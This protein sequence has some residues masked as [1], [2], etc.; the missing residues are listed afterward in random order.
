MDGVREE[1]FSIITRTFNLVP[2]EVT[3]DT[4]ALDVDGWD[5]LRHTELL[6]DIEE[7]FGLEL[8]MAQVQTAETV[9]ELA[10]VIHEAILDL[11]R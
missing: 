3:A 6:L 4:M 1:V 9:G 2:G 10:D 8:P 7:F 11:A 5:S